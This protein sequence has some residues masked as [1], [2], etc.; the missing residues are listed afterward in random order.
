MK[1]LH[2]KIE[3]E[4]LGLT[5]SEAK[6][7]NPFENRSPKDIEEPHM[8]LLRLMRNPDY[9]Y[10]TC[11]ALFN[12]PDGKPLELLPFQC[13]IL[14]EMWY[15]PF[16]MLIA[17]RGA[18]KSFILGLYAVLRALFIQGR[19]IVITGSGFRQAKTVFNY[20]E[21]IW[22][23]SPILRSLVSENAQSGPHH[24]ADRWWLR[25]GDS[26]ITALPLGDGQKIRG[27]RAHDIIAD[28]FASIPPETFETVVAGFGVVNLAPVA[29]VKE[30]VRIRV[31]KQYKLW[32]EQME[33]EYRKNNI[34]NQTIISGT[35]Y[36]QFNHF[37]TYWKKYKGYIESRGDEKRLKEV[38]KNTV[39]ANFN[40]R[41][42][43]IIRMHVGMLPE[44]FMDDNMVARSKAEQHTGTFLNEFG[45]V[46]SSDSNG[47]YKRSLVE[48]CVT[49]TPII[50]AGEPVQF[51]ATTRGNPN[52]HYV[53]GIDPA[54]EADRF[55]IVILE[56]YPT[57]R[58]VVYC[59]TTT[60]KEF[61]DRVEGHLTKETDFY[62]FCGR[63]IRDLMKIFPCEH[64]ALDS[65]GGG[66]AVAEALHD[67]DKLEQGEV[68]LWPITV[69]HPLSDGK[70]RP[71]DAYPGGHILELVNFAKS[72]WTSEANHGMRKDFEDKVLLFPEFDAALVA[73]AMEED[74]HHNRIYD[75]LEDAVKEVEDLKEELATI[76]HTQTP[77][78][79]RDHWDTPEIKTE[80]SKKGRLRK[81]RYSALLMANSA[82]RRLNRQREEPDMVPWGGFVDQRYA[83]AAPSPANQMYMSGPDWF[84]QGIKGTKENYGWVIRPDGV[85]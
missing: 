78:T 31:L 11:K 70:E 30:R 43:S 81:D 29:K 17:S 38:F 48:S 10:F 23:N 2:E 62:G 74:S 3:L 72:E 67:N 8:H 18:G 12:G 1:D 7:V 19:K 13:V 75:T 64:I 51:R 52:C 54:S 56:V 60:R 24:D 44:G 37:A 28:E 14:K 6:I 36:Y 9:F 46:F 39:P 50:V 47:F 61:R 82:A 33:E 73:M 5:A 53:Y 32:N 21:V 35:A 79:F 45:A 59:W 34:G 20:A 16:P 58:R 4:F 66:V 83:V 80:G 22:H 49:N 84:T 69:D 85:E 26:T 41:N 77:G 65:Q 57:H 71:S 42:Y 25:L 63:K 55:S 68:P 40:Y 27:E 76:I 15:R